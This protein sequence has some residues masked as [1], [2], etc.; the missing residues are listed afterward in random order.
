MAAEPVAVA[1][2]VTVPIFDWMAL[3]PAATCEAKQ[4]RCGYVVAAKNWP[5]LL[6]EPRQDQR[7][8]MLGQSS[9]RSC[10]RQITRQTNQGH[11][12]LNLR[13]QIIQ[14]VM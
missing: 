5:E 14:S 2:A 11:E 8:L 6:F 3:D 1:A 7:H 9:L 4:T 13:M 10:L 12:P